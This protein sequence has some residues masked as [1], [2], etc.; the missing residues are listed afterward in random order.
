M[1]SMRRFGPFAA[2][3][4]EPLEYPFN[5]GHSLPG[6][7]TEGRVVMCNEPIASLLHQN[8]CEA[9]RL[10]RELSILVAHE[11]IEANDQDR[12]VVEHLELP[13]PKLDLVSGADNDS[14]VFGD[15]LTTYG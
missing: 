11:V 13:L 5:K 4:I 1:G 3:F 6:W 12:L 15:S 2:P 8:H 10:W 7:W 14:E 9:G